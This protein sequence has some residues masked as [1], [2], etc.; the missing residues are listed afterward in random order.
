MHQN[1]ERLEINTAATIIDKDT[2]DSRS[3]DTIDQSVCRAEVVR[4]SCLFDHGL[5]IAE[6]FRVDCFLSAA[7]KPG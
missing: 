7:P 6:L 5:V 3:V 1:K 4:I 2:I